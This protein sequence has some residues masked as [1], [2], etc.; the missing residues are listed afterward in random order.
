MASPLS[1][2]LSSLLDDA[3][4]FD[5]IRQHRWPKA[6]GVRIAMTPRRFPAMGTMTLSRTASGIGA[7]RVARA[8]TTCGTVLAGHH[9]PLRVWVLCLDF[10]GLRWSRTALSRRTRSMSLP[11]IR[12]IK[13]PSKKGRPGRRRRLKGAPGRGTLDK[14][15]PPILGLIQPGGEVDLRMLGNVQQVTIR[16]IIEATVAR[17]SLIHTD[18]YDIYARL[19]DWGYSHKSVC[20]SRGEYARDD[21][22]DG[23][24]EVQSTPWKA[25]G[26]CCSPGS[27]RIVASRRR[28]CRRISASSSSSTTCTDAAKPYSPP[29]SPPW[30]PEPDDHPGTRYEPLGIP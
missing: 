22:G 11:I 10:M 18:E 15:K 25:S 16:P 19:E 24:C 17:G 20:H 30:S 6:S 2:N 21:D 9:Q 28:S 3:K 4:C 8:S 1:V 27:V 23:F 13:P 5:L 7:R 12:A 14:E 26:R 29:S